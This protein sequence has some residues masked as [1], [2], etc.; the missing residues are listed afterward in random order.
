MSSKYDKFPTVKQRVP[1]S[2][3]S[4]SSSLRKC[5][6][7]GTI[8]YKPTSKPHLSGHTLEKTYYRIVKGE[9]NEGAFFY[10]VRDYVNGKIL[11]YSPPN[12]KTEDIPK[13][14][15]DAKDVPKIIDDR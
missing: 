15:K 7:L 8:I 10:I 14:L 1:Q 5:R 9:K 13:K 3:I 6:N 4:L 11:D 2:G 12:L